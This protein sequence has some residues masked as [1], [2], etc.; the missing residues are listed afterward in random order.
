MLR[1]LSQLGRV[2]AGSIAAVAEATA[3]LHA[4]VPPSTLGSLR[5][6]ASGPALGKPSI[7]AGAGGEAPAS[8]SGASGGT[9]AG[10]LQTKGEWREWIDTKL[11]SKIE[12]TFKPAAAAAKKAKPAGLKP[13]GQAR[14]KKAKGWELE[15]QI[16]NL[17]APSRPVEEA[18]LPEGVTSYAQL[19][20]AADAPRFARGSANVADVSPQRVHPTRLFFPQQS[21][22]PAELDPYKGSDEAVA[23]MEAASVA[24][25]LGAQEVSKL[26][27]YKNVPMLATF[28]SEAGKLPLR[29]RTH[30]RAKLHRHL[31]RQI[32]LARCMGLLSPTARWEPTKEAKEEAKQQERQERRQMQMKRQKQQEQ[33]QQ[34]AQQQRQRRAT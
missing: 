2:P 5:L 24:T 25:M 6:F 19:A 1:A 4:A 17:V 3:G 21:Y 33:T 34:T 14:T 12:S 16:Y 20:M 13:M 28:L 30:L 15:Q 10:R 29:E 9:K 11:D 22:A 18:A 27:D 32:K 26:A 8:S 31:S 7:D 23:A